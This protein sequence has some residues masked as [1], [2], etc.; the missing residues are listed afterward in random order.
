VEEK[1]ESRVEMM[2]E[3]ILAHWWVMLLRGVLLVVAG[4]FTLAMPAGTLIGVVLFLGIYWIVDGI[5][6]LVEGIRGARGKRRTWSIISALIGVLAGLLVIANPLVA[7]MVSSTLLAYLIGITVLLRGTTLMFVGRD[8]RWTWQ[9]L[10]MGILYVLF[11]IVII[12]RPLVAIAVLMWI[13]AILAIAAGIV[14]VG[15]SFRMRTGH[16]RRSASG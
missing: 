7:G 6:S 4:I 13:F 2:R 8:Q 12:A 16:K 14:S 3:K 9:G 11:G 1:A 5:I 15:I 10:L